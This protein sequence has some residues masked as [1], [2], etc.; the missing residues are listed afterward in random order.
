MVRQKDN[1]KRGAVLLLALGMAISLAGCGKGEKPAQR[2][3]QRGFETTS[4]AGTGG[5]KVLSGR[6]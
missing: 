3:R 2:N 5:R 4:A 6:I 1:K